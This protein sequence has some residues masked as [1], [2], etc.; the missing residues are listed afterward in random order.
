MV[1]LCIFRVCLVNLLGDKIESTRCLLVVL[2]GELVLMEAF[3][4]S[5]LKEGKH[6]FGLP[7]LKVCLIT[8]LL[9]RPLVHRLALLTKHRRHP[10]L[11]YRFNSTAGHLLR[12]HVLWLYRLENLG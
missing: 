5:I 9:L 3:A 6:L 7:T 4:A 1:R 12:E 11:L 10:L 8:R 2:G